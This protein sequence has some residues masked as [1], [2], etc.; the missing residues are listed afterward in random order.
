MLYYYR[1]LKATVYVLKELLIV[2][3]SLKVTRVASFASTK[4]LC[5]FESL[6]S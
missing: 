6:N 4:K 3:F 5:S 2:I 1:C